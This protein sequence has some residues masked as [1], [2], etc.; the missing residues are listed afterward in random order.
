MVVV[1]KM[2]SIGR[3]VPSFWF[4]PVHFVTENLKWGPSLPSTTSVV[5]RVLPTTKR[6]QQCWKTSLLLHFPSVGLQIS[7]TRIS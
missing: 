7:L 1:I 3:Q 6:P 5:K 2:K 4:V